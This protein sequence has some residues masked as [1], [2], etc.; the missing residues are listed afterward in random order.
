MML[1]RE[2]GITQLHW[3]LVWV[4][5]SQG[6]CLQKNAG[7]S[8]SFWRPCFR[9]IRSQGFSQWFWCPIHGFLKGAVVVTSSWPKCCGNN[10]WRC[11]FEDYGKVAYFDMFASFFSWCHWRFVKI[12]SVFL[13]PS[14][15]FPFIL[16]VWV[17]MP[18]CH[19]RDLIHPHIIFIVSYI[20]W[21]YSLKS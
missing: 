14:C 4:H 2:G 20:E 1:W 7:A 21:R 12:S 10:N 6:R 13:F 8:A 19:R 16:G 15:G 11:N 3:N 5:T 9:S 17:H 18:S